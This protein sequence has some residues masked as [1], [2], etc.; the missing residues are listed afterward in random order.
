MP[1]IDNPDNRPPS[2]GHARRPL[3]AALGDANRH[4]HGIGPA[5][6]QHLAGRGLD[7]TLVS[8]DAE[9]TASADFWRGHDP[10][11]L[12]EPVC[13]QPCHPGRVHR[14]VMPRP[15]AGHLLVFAV[16][17]GDIGNGPGLSPAVA[18]ATR[19]VA[20]AIAAEL[21]AVDPPARRW[22]PAVT[23]AGAGPGA[24]AG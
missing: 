7:V 13:V 16:E 2:P 6:L 23:W 4:D 21:D 10:A 17:T 8:C 5:V 9:T 24:V 20:D 14:M 19:R 15:D 3:V 18:A 1:I 12:V 22:S 11:I